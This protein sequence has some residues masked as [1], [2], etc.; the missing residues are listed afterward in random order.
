M[1]LVVVIDLASKGRIKE[2]ESN[3]LMFSEN[4]MD[5]LYEIFT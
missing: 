1:L 3:V 5:Y 4:Q 2:G